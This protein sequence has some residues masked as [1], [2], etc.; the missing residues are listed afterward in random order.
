MLNIGPPRMCDEPPPLYFADPRLHLDIKL[1]LLQ[2]YRPHDCGRVN[3][4]GEG[5]IYRSELS[6]MVQGQPF[7]PEHGEDQWQWTSGEPTPPASPSPDT[8]PG[9]AHLTSSAQ[10]H[11]FLHHLCLFCCF[12]ILKCCQRYYCLLPPIYF[13]CI[14]AVGLKRLKCHLYCVSAMYD[15]FDNKVDLT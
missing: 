9:T 1:Q 12:F 2:V 11:L 15:I 13:Y 5:T 14:F 10:F 3:S 4:Q 8:H 7:L 6:H